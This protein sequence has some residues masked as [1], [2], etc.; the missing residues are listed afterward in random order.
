MTGA[1][2]TPASPASFL[3]LEHL[4]KRFA[5]TAAVED[6]SL[7]ID[8]G[9][10]LALLGPSGS[11]KTTTLRLLAGFEAPDTGRIVLEGQDVTRTTPVGRRFGMVFQHYALFP[12]LDVAENVAFG[13]R[14]R[15]VRGDALG[16]R[17]GEALRLVDLAGFERRRV[18][19]LSGG[20]SSGWP[21]RAPWPR[22]R[23]CC[24]WMSRSRISTRRFGSGPAG[25]SGA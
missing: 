12:H 7:A 25:S 21:S 6:L 8:R 9:E 4:T 18:T 23:A 13:L 3:R 19:E 1:G 11:G 2:S 17:I 16:Q 15:G 22:N 5:G 20:S 14:S 10:I 24:S